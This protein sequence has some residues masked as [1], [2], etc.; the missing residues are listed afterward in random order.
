MGHRRTYAN[1]NLDKL[2]YNLEQIHAETDKSLFCVVKANA[3]GHGIVEISKH[4]INQPHVKYLCVSSIDEALLLRGHL[5]EFPIINLGYTDIEDIETCIDNNITVS[6]PS[7]DWFVS[8]SSLP[9]TL[10]ELKVHVK[11]DTGM[12]RL[13]IKGIYEYLDILSLANELNIKF[14]GIFSHYHSSD[15]EDNSSS[16]K[17]LEMFEEILNSSQYNYNW[18]HIANSEAIFDITDTVSNAVRCGL[19]MYGYSSKTTRYKPILSLYTTVTQIKKVSPNE[20]ISYSASHIVE[21]EKRIA[22]LPIGYADGLNRK[23][24]NNNLFIDDTPVKI[25]G[26]ICMDQTI[27]EYPLTINNKIVEI[28]GN[29]QD[30]V[31]LAEHLDTIPY[32]ILSSLS[33]RI[34]R[35]YFERDRLIFETSI[36]K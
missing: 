6:L 26:R 33:Y 3:Y 31:D 28:I 12:N 15:E 25:I 19:S 32:E 1:I 27:I 24:Q 34:T 30:A 29:H 4:L 5:T 17:Q 20:S 8:L 18:I 11:V 21:E 7:L 10:S 14:E 13:G 2:D 23:L 22:V 35:K 16:Y 36:I 9:F